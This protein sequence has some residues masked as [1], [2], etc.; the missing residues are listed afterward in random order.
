MT[1]L[2]KKFPKVSIIIVNWNTCDILKNCLQSVYAQ[3]QPDLVEVIVVDN[4]STDNSCRM[5]QTLFPGLLLIE[6]AGNMGFAKANNQAITLARGEYLLLLNSDTIILDNAVAKSLAF[7]E[8]N[9]DAAVIGCRVLN[10]DRTPQPSCFMFPSILNMLI[11]VCCINRL[12]SRSRF[13]GREEMTWWNGTDSREVDVVNGC[14]MLVRRQAVEQVGMLDERFFMY[15]EE[16]DWCYRFGKAGWKTIFYPNAEIIHLNGQ[17]TRMVRTEMLVQLRIS[18]LKFIYKHYGRPSHKIA[19]FLSTFFFAIR[20]PVWLV[21]FV[22][23]PSQKKRAEIKLRAYLSGIRR[24]LSTSEGLF[25]K[26][27]SV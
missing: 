16:A 14:F 6:N 19:C 4:G 22:F 8:A 24:I 1:P 27:N 26:R 13:F 20:M 25:A 23:V 17:S 7:A 5:V 11:S 9:P 21:A 18:I 2:E 3:T 12:F 15:A 10:P